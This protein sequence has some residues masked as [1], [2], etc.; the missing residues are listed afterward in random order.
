MIAKDQV[1]SI[2]YKLTSDSGDVIDSSEGRDPL[3]Y[4]HGHGN[5]VPGL[6]NALEGRKVGDEFQVSIPP[7]DGY[8]ERDETQ[9]AKVPRSNV[10]IPGVKAGMTAQVQTAQGPLRVQIIDVNDEEV[11]LDANHELAGETLNFD[12]EVVDVRPADASEIDHGHPH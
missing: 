5:I 2:H 10:N 3:A 7:A 6:E 12:I 4:L 1:V 9:I 8:G 11:T